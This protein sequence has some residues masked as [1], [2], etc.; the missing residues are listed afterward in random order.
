MASGLPVV[1]PA[2]GGPLDLVA[3]GRTGYLVAPHQRAGFTLAVAELTADAARRRAFGAAGR[4]AVHGSGWA[5][6]GDE[7]IG[8]Y[9]A[10]LGVSPAGQVTSGSG[11]RPLP[12]TTSSIHRLPLVV[13]VDSP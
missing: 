6:I 5:A 11:L 4:E 3:H 9:R 8:H 1:A 10:A 12:A 7:L 2:A 13:D